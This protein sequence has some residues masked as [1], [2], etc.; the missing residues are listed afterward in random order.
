MATIKPDLRPRGRASE[1]QEPAEALCR[2]LSARPRGLRTYRSCSA[3]RSSIAQSRRAS[4]AA[5]CL[6]GGLRL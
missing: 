2:V 4:K 1:G 5:R 3:V 6:P